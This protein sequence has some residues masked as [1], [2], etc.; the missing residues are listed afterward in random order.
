MTAPDCPKCHSSKHVVVSA[1]CSECQQE[2]DAWIS[3]ER[4]E[5]TGCKTIAQLE[6]ALARAIDERDKNV[7]W[8]QEAVA[9]TNRVALERDA[10]IESV[11]EFGRMIGECGK[12]LGLS[13]CDAED[14]GDAVMRVVA[15]RDALRGGQS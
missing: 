9:L 10:A 11:R 4:G 5:L 12:A 14:V 2:F 7:M 15:E 6:R 13:D 3:G 8:R 1:F